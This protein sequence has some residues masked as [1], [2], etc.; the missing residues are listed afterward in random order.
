MVEI[1][2]GNKVLAG[3]TE[4]VA[5]YFGN[6]Y[7]VSKRQNIYSKM[8][9]AFQSTDKTNNQPYATPYMVHKDTF[10]TMANEALRARLQCCTKPFCKSLGNDAKGETLSDL[11]YS[12]DG[13]NVSIAAETGCGTD[14]DFVKMKQAEKPRIDAVDV[15]LGHV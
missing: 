10:R 6:I 11:W 5:I 12:R 9:I 1:L 8:D 13:W 14:V 3:C 2:P 7:S 15:F 4:G